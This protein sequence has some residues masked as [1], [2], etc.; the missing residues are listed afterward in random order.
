MKDHLIQF[1]PVEAVHLALYLQQLA[2]SKGS[3]SA[4]EEAVNSLAWIHTLAGLLSPHCPGHIRW[5]QKDSGQAR[6]QEITVYG[7]NFEGNCP[8]C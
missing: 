1:F 2:D 7:G 6:E 4:V 5:V 3:K 8:R